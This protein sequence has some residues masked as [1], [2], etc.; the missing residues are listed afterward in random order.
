[1]SPAVLWK[2]ESGCQWNECRNCGATLVATPNEIKM[3][4]EEGIGGK[5]TH[6]L[7]WDRLNLG[8]RMQGYLPISLMKSRT[9][10]LLWYYAM[11]WPWGGSYRCDWVANCGLISEL[12]GPDL[13][14]SSRLWSTWTIN[15]DDIKGKIWNFG[16]DP[17]L[18][19]FGRDPKMSH[20]G[21]D[22]KRS[23]FGRDPK[24]N[25]DRSSS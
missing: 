25:D 14:F 12:L 7:D 1:M 13:G 20:F 10:L 6:L 8:G 17:C 2:N 19:L 9:D 24:S 18:S 4:K 5:E 23:H 16:H 3:K 11:R 21:R 22:P 15:W